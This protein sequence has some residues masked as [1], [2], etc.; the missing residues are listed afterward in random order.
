M[1][2]CLCSDFAPDLARLA[3]ASPDSE[4]LLGAAEGLV[5]KFGPGGGTA[6][7]TA[8]CASAELAGTA[9]VP[10]AMLGPL[11]LLWASG[12]LTGF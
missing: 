12:M 5:Q 3:R 9:G 1:L 7:A 6:A 8:W 10:V 4:G 2:L 11:E